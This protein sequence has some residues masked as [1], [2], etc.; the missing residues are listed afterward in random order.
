MTKNK[1]STRYYSELH[2]KSIAKA[3]NAELNPNSGAGKWRKGDLCKRDASLLIEAKCSMTDKNSF[4]VKKE[5]IEKNK[6]EAFT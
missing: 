3:L 6:Q 5:W 4:S 2:E 1:E